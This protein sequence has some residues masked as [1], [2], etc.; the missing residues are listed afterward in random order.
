MHRSLQ[1]FENG[2][3]SLFLLPPSTRDKEGHGEWWCYSGFQPERE[4]G[5][6]SDLGGILRPTFEAWGDYF[7]EMQKCPEL[8][9]MSKLQIFEHDHMGK[10]VLEGRCGQGA[11]RVIILE[12]SN[13]LL[14]A[15]GIIFKKS[16]MCF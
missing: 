11:S 3:I 1:G 12:F 5:C 2:G 15:F 10:M 6:W 14:L 7:D 9:I 16:R 4:V 13:H 8:I